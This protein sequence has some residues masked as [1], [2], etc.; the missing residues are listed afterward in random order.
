MEVSQ[1]WGVPFLGVPIIP[2][3]VFWGIYWGPLILGIHHVNH[4]KDS[5]RK[6]I[7]LGFRMKGLG[8][9]GVSVSVWKCAA[10]QEEA[11][12]SPQL[13]MEPANGPYY[14]CHP[15]T[16]VFVRLNGVPCRLLPS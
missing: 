5:K 7:G 12:H 4:K 10:I 15:G 6:T 3:I 8:L 1:N 16:Q 9:R 14:Q 2:S 11:L 13:N